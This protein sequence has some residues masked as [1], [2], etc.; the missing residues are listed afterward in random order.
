MLHNLC[1]IQIPE[2]IIND[3]IKPIVNYT[4]RT[5]ILNTVTRIVEAYE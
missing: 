1:A 3:V 5:F 2:K 4:E